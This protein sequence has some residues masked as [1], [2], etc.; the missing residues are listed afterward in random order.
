[1]LPSY[2]QSFRTR[3]PIRMATRPRMCTRGN[4][5]TRI[6]GRAQYAAVELAAA[7]GHAMLQVACRR[8]ANCFGN[9]EGLCSTSVARPG[10]RR[11]VETTRATARRRGPCADVAG[12]LA[13]SRM[14]TLEQ[15]SQTAKKVD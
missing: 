3:L 12:R 2:I 6:W 13:I 10:R 15:R 8:R 4:S 14:L 1:M 9:A 11:G 7:A 5:G